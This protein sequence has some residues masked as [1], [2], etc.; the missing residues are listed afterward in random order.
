MKLTK[1][2]FSTFIICF[3]IFENGFSQCDNSAIEYIHA[4]KVRAAVLNDGSFF[5]NRNDGR[6]LVPY[7]LGHLTPSTIF[8]GSLW[9]GGV[10]NTD[11][12]K[13]SWSDDGKWFISG[14]IDNNT[15][16]INDENCG[17]FDRIWKITQDDILSV[18]ED[19]QDDGMVDQPIPYAVKSWPAKGNPFF[20][21]IFGFPLPDQK[22]APFFDRNGNELF[23]PLMGE[24]PILDPNFPNAV[25]N[26]MTWS[27]FN[28]TAN[29]HNSFSELAIGAEVH[30]MTCL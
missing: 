16:T 17:N 15:L 22:L 10:D 13:T 5:W 3:L 30:L 21:G 23:E 8:A 11:N 27:V 19:F 24:Y 1:T 9:L 29:E 20:E 26:E 2:I 4:N 6:F 25:P 18:K 7:T 14:P 28:S 12:L